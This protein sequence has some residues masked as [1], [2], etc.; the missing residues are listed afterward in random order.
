MGGSLV[1]CPSLVDLPAPS[2]TKTGWP[3]TSESPQLPRVM[4]DGSA[5]PRVSIVTPSLNMGRY[6]E[7][8]IRS[9]LLQGY[10][11]LQYIVIDGGSTDGSV[12]IIRKYDRWIEHW[13]SEPDRSHGHAINKGFERVNGPIVAW[14]SS[15]DLYLPG[16]FTHAVE[17][18][19]QRPEVGIVY[20]ICDMINADGSFYRRKTAGSLDLR[21]LVGEVYFWQQAVFMR[22]DALRKAGYIDERLQLSIDWDLWLR[23]ATVCDGAY[24]PVPLAKFRFWVGS[25]GA[26]LTRRSPQEKRRVLR[27]FAA[28]HDLDHHVVSAIQDAI[29]VEYWL[30]G[31][32]LLDEGRRLEGFGLMARALVRSPIVTWRK[33]TMGWLWMLL[34]RGLRKA[35]RPTARWFL[36]RSSSPGA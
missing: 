21:R 6:L 33:C 8:T 19:V 35:L 17:A 16:A 24:L 4:P 25:A 26:Q 7:E 20:G 23:M 29:S 14:M 9:V 15:D 13:V 2:P 5:W 28:S 3:W 31:N 18:F 34:P 10:P 11:N 27:R 22:N 32:Y 36:R 30:D 1:R 12:E